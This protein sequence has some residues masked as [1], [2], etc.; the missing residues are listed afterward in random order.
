[1]RSG[2]PQARAEPEASAPEDVQKGDERRQ[3]PD[4]NEVVALSVLGSADDKGHGPHAGQDAAEGDDDPWPADPGCADGERQRESEH[5][6]EIPGHSSGIGSTAGER[7]LRLAYDRA[8][9]VFPDAERL[10]QLAL[11]DDERDEH[12]DAVRVDP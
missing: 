4:R 8:E 10:V 7:E 6:D 9:R 11:R 12:A 2:F 3:E 5:G 1:M